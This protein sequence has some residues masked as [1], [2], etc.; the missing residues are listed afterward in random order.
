MVNNSP[1]ISFFRSKMLLREAEDSR[2]RAGR[3]I[4]AIDEEWSSEDLTKWP[5]L[6]VGNLYTV[7][8]IQKQGSVHAKKLRCLQIIR[9]L[10][11]LL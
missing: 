5:E 10:Q 9:G 1:L 6:E 4:C 8:S 11:L 3:S 7:L 2:S